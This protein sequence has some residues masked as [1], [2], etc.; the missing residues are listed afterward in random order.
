MKVEVEEDDNRQCQ[1]AQMIKKDSDKLNLTVG[2]ES[3][4]TE[5]DS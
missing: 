3:D 4:V 5:A 2:R 1:G